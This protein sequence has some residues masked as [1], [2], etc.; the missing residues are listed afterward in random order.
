MIDAEPR[1]DLLLVLDAPS[2]GAEGRMIVWNFIQ[3][4]GPLNMEHVN[5]L[6]T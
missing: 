3:A 1:R 2:A 5:V 6:C 4:N